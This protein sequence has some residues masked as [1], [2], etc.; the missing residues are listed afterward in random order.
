MTL[1][2]AGIKEQGPISYSYIT[3]SIAEA[4]SGLDT[5]CHNNVELSEGGVIYR[6]R[7][8][9]RRRAAATGKKCKPYNCYFRRL[10]SISLSLSPDKKY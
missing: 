4:I 1:S 8:R 9:R 7:G 2:F 6:R 10:P 5:S 3:T